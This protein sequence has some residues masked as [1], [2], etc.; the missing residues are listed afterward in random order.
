MPEYIDPI[1]QKFGFKKKVCI[2]LIKNTMK[3]E[4]LCNIITIY[5][6]I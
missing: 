4:I 3:T 2:Y 6:Y 1:V 5:I